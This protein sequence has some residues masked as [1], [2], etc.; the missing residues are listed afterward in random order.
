M[1]F[2]KLMKQYYQDK[3]NQIKE[4]NLRPLPLKN[5]LSKKK[6]FFQ[7]TW[8][9]ALG[10]ALLIGSVFYNIYRDPGLIFLPLLPGISLPF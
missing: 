5:Y 7:L 2:K 6:V 10:Y 1:N 3:I 8:D 4:I 9:S